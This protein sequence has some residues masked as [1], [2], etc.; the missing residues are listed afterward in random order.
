MLFSLNYLTSFPYVSGVTQ[1]ILI[2]LFARILYKVVHLRF[3][4]YSFYHFPVVYTTMYE[5]WRRFMDFR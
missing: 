3:V 4:S 5:Y 2:T 1:F